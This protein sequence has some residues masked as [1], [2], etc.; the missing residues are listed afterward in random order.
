MEHLAYIVLGFT[1]LQWVI[2]LSNML[3]RQKLASGPPSSSLVSVL[4]PARNEAHNLPHL[5]ND[6][7]AQD[8]ERMEILVF[9]DQSDDDTPRITERFAEFDTRVKLIR[10]EGLPEG[11]L[12]KNHA[13][14][15]LAKQAKGSYL[16]FVDAD[17]RLGV[18][19]VRKAVSTAERYSLGLLSIFPTQHMKS[20]GERV[21]VPIMNYAL[22]TLLPLI[23]VRKSPFVSH[24]AAN[25]QFMLFN[26]DA[27][28]TYWPHWKMK[29]KK[30]EDVAIARFFKR[31]HEKVA[32]MLGDTNIACRMY[33]GY[34]QA[35]QG[36]SKNVVSFFGNSFALAFLF[37]IIT[38]FGIVP[39]A[40]SFNTLISTVYL[41]SVVS[42]RIMVSIASRQS[43]VKNTLLLVIQ[44]LVIGHLILLSIKYKLNK[45]YKWKG[46]NIL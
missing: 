7:A 9:D 19:A 44:Q 8:F 27:Y 30:A 22:L 40:Y 43:T 34:H 20:F 23:W 18:D 2:A 12:G 37:W 4:I 41:L 24:S 21:T 28:R 29:T 31:H 5:L 10:S 13:C 6:L 36:F 46:R 15:Q 35:T 3:F 25:G 45:G 11:W 16:L 14:H 42:I 17:V 33:L 32:A 39:V 38:S 1:A 26:A